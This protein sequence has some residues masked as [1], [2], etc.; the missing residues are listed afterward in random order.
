MQSLF[1]LDKADMVPPGKVATTMH[2][3]EAPAAELSEYEKE[4]GKPKPSFN[5]ALVQ[6]AII[7]SFLPS[8]EFSVLRELTLGLPTAAD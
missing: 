7:G 8:R 4:R 2:T 5:H 3:T 1:S 6:T